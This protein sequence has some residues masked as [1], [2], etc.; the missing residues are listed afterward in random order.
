MQTGFILLAA[1]LHRHPLQRYAATHFGRNRPPSTIQSGHWKRRGLEPVPDPGGSKIPHCRE[2][3]LS[4][5]RSL[6][7]AEKTTLRAVRGLSSRTTKSAG[8]GCNRRVQTSIRKPASTTAQTHPA[9][10]SI[11]CREEVLGPIMVAMGRGAD[12]WHPS[13]LQS[14]LSTKAD[15]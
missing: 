6:E 8:P 4:R 10:S 7:L 11:S 1:P 5:G 13:W 14:E 3:R 15:Y 12:D 2:L 9:V